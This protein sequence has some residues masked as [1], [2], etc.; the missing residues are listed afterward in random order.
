[1][2]VWGCGAACLRMAVSDAKAGTVYNP[3]LSAGGLALPLL[4][5]P[6]ILP[7][8]LPRRSRMAAIAALA[9]ASAACGGMGAPAATSAA[10]AQAGT[11]TGTY[12][13]TV[14]AQSG[15]VTNQSQLQL[16]VN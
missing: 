10:P 2:I 7:G 9:L 3:P 14:V 4:M 11:P 1:V 6:A 16:T 15:N 13:V 5:L 8:G 12:Q